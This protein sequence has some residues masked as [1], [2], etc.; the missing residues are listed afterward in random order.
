[1]AKLRL[2]ARS[3][4]FS[5]F[6]VV[7][8]LALLILHTFFNGTAHID[9]TSV[10]LLLVIV[11]IPYLPWITRIKFGSFE[12]EIGRDE[13]RE[14]E[15]NLESSEQ[16]PS[17]DS[18][19]DEELNRIRETALSD[20][21]VAFL[22]IRIAIERR[23]RSLLTIYV[24][25][26]S[27]RSYLSIRQSIEELRIANVIDDQLAS[28]L[29]DVVGVANRA[30]HGESVSRQNLDS[31]IDLSLRA[32]HSLDSLLID[33]AHKNMKVK[34]IDLKTVQTKQYANYVVKTI[35][36]LAKDPEERTYHLNQAELDAFLE[37]YDG[38]AEFITSVRETPQRKSTANV[39]KTQK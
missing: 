23:L 14:I 37:D 19:P 9:N 33:R 24:P 7:V 26:K 18:A 34:R 25:N 12:A 36:P 38:N 3:R 17:A 28:G 4:T 21:A 39:S 15:K 29:L 11:L 16:Q 35:V 32:I 13:I 27:K 5:I 8:T 10:F 2:A 22:K 30:V 6:F 1:M 31:M 20:P